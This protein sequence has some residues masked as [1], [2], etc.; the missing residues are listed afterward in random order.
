[1]RISDWSS[2][3]CSSDLR[4]D[5]PPDRRVI[6]LQLHRRR[7]RAPSARHRKK[8]PKIIPVEMH[9]SLLP[10]GAARPAAALSRPAILHR[11]STSPTAPHHLHPTPTPHTKPQPPTPQQP[12]NTHSTTPTTPQ[13][14]DNN[15][16]TLK[17]H[18]TH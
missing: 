13:H 10:H 12:T 4:I 1:M 17:K 6:D 8:K 9:A 3:V 11:L 7:R 15:K 2:D 18:N 5:P 14:N 16:P